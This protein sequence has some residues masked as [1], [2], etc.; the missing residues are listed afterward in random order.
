MQSFLIIV[1]FGYSICNNLSRYF[2]STLERYFISSFVHSKI[3]STPFCT[4][5]VFYDYRYFCS[6]GVKFER[7]SKSSIYFIHDCAQYLLYF[8]L[9]HYVAR[10]ERHIVP[11][12]KPNSIWRGNVE[13]P[14][15]R[16][17]C[18]RYPWWEFCASAKI[19]TAYYLYIRI[20]S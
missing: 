14:L 20:V 6:T 3:N 4:I 11:R 17:A 5:Y 19:S 18:R 7:K 8:S 10:S 1:K 13:S 12:K 16:S 15:E 2:I 9:F